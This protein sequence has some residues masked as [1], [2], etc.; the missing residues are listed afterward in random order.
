[1]SFLRRIVAAGLRAVRAFARRRDGG[2]ALE[3]AM[4]APIFVVLIFAT[5]QVAIIY[6]AEAYLE[7]AA[8]DAARTVLT[9]QATSMTASQF[10]TAVCNDMPA[11]F[12]CGNVMVNLTPAASETSINTSTPTFNSNGTLA[13][14]TTYTM[15][16]PG[17]IAVLQVFYEWPVI[18]LPLGFNFGNLGNGAYLMLS[19]QVFIVEAQ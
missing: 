1:M 9:N 17:Q 12:T 7:T 14:P 19:T 2:T 18:G 4:I 15:P 5:A 3:F 11:L 8:E 10:Q 16:I 13:N 6:L